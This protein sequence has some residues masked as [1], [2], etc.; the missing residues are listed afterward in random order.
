MVCRGW[1]AATRHS[2]RREATI[3]NPE[4][5]IPYWIPDLARRRRTRPVR[6]FGPFPD[7]FSSLL[8]LSV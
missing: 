1:K 6:R 5:T 4:N 3:R 7:F 2:G 8:V